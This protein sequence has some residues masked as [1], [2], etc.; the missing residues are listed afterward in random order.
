MVV[1]NT[2]SNYK[3]NESETKTHYKDEVKTNY[4]DF[5]DIDL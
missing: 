2:L 5:E 3:N 4:R 1:E